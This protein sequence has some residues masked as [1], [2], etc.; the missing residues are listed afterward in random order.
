MRVNTSKIKFFILTAII[1]S[2][3][4]ASL[5][6]H[7][8]GYDVKEIIENITNHRYLPMAYILL[9]LSS[10]FLPLPFLTFIGAA[11][12]PFWEALIY[13]L[14]GNTLEMTITFYLVKWLGRSYVK[15]YEKKY[16]KIRKIDM[17]FTKNAFRDVIL[18][19][20]F[21]II[22]PGAVTIASGVS[23]MKFKDF[24]LASILGM[25]PLSLASIFLIK[26]K[27]SGSMFLFIASVFLFILLL[28]IP[29]IFV[30]SLRKYVRKKYNSAYNHGK[31][32]LK[33]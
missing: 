10:I 23:K 2:S 21:F 15:V 1:I 33:K 28:V 3:I 29:I 18:L 25:I 13:S 27:I 11:V 32:F 5:I 22:P 16:K 9:F 24:I 30:A 31:N 26:S 12:F 19:R 4:I 7:A 14:L 8:Q 6:L 17:Q 20:F